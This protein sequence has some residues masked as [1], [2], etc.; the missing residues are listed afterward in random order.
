MLRATS[1]RLASFSSVPL[2]TVYQR[3]PVPSIPQAPITTL[4]VLVRSTTHYPG[5]I[6]EPLYNHYGT[7]I[8]QVVG[9]EGRKSIIDSVVQEVKITKDDKGA[10]HLTG[11]FVYGEEGTNS[12]V[13]DDEGMILGRSTLHLDCPL[14]EPEVPVRS[15]APRSDTTRDYEE[16]RE[17]MME[18]EMSAL[19]ATNPLVNGV[20]DTLP[21]KNITHVEYRSHPDALGKNNRKAGF[22]AE[23]NVRGA[24]DPTIQHPNVNT[25]AMP[26]TMDNADRARMGYDPVA[27]FE[28]SCVEVC[29]AR[30][31]EGGDPAP[32]NVDSLIAVT[33]YAYRNPDAAPS[34]PVVDSPIDPTP[35]LDYKQATALARKARLDLQ[36]AA[37]FTFKSTENNLA[38]L[39]K[40]EEHL[41]SRSKGASV[42]F[43]GE[44][45][46]Q[47][48][49]TREAV[50]SL[51][52]AARAELVQWCTEFKVEVPA[53]A[54]SKAPLYASEVKRDKGDAQEK[55]RA[56]ILR[57]RV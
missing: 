5:N 3:P 47:E 25:E 37:D 30:L 13:V 55:R 53:F 10:L 12:V 17:G 41:V 7:E 23:Y 11:Q 32:S 45:R 52:E 2:K 36:T 39:D 8:I 19:D 20:R 22:R 43:K 4:T 1:S 56:P 21:F 46:A 57:K 33:S 40:F 44:S 14:L 6:V 35:V 31:A 27:P 50:E 18:T 24:G 15:N 26:A 42:T 16:L 34:S 28:L 54:R 48:Q 9:E 38:S 51:R 49:S 29:D